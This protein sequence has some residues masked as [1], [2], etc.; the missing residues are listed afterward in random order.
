MPRNVYEGLFIFD[1]IRY[2]R[3]PDVLSRQI[4]Q[5]I[6]SAGGEV[7]V[8]RLWEER[9]LAYPIKGH[10]KGTYWLTYFRVDSSRLQEVHRASRLNEAILRFMFVKVDPRLV[11]TLVQHALGGPRPRPQPAAATTPTEEYAGVD[12]ISDLE[13]LEDEEE[14]E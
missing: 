6:E 5:M 12:A 3:E 10:R 9:R 8:S 4:T 13:D 11:D 7:L 1:P 14:E 2:A